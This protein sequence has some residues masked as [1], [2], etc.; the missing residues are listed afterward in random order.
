MSHTKSQ[1]DTSI[2]PTVS[3]IKAVPCKHSNFSHSFCGK[4]FDLFFGGIRGE[5]LNYEELLDVKSNH[6]GNYT[7][8]FISY[9]SVCV[10][11]PR[12]NNTRDLKFRTKKILFN[13]RNTTVRGYLIFALM[14]VSYPLTE[15]KI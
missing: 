2:L 5:K 8:T 14:F 9:I 3:T 12:T 7:F 6:D 1:L 10:S 11:T 13:P 4:G 15:P